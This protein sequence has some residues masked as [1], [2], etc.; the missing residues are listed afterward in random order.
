MEVITIETKAFQ[1]II[2]RISEIKEI[3][4]R[5]EKQNPFSETWLDIKETCTLLK[6]SKRTLQKY[7]DNGLFA[8]SQISGK[9]YFKATDLEEILKKHYIKAFASKQ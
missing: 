9:I 6:I 5:K 3:L 8:F 1:E 7:R 4:V 2:N